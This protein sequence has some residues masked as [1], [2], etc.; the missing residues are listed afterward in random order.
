MLSGPS[1]VGQTVIKSYFGSQ[2]DKPRPTFKYQGFGAQSLAPD[3]VRRF[4]PRPIDPQLRMEIESET[5]INS[6]GGAQFSPDGKTLYFH[7]NVSGA[8]QIWKLSPTVPFPVQMTSGEDST[9]L[10]DITPDGLSLIESRDHGG[11]EY[12][13]IYRQKSSGGRLEP[14][15]VK[16]QVKAEPQFI[17]EDGRYLY[18]ISNEKAPTSYGIYKLDLKT[19]ERQVVLEDPGLWSVADHRPDGTLLLFK[20]TAHDATEFFILPPNSLK[21]EPLFGQGEHDEYQ[22]RFGSHEGEVLVLTNKFG[23]FRRLY[24]YR[25]KQ[26]IPLTPDIHYDVSGFQV[27]RQRKRILYTINQAGEDS[28]GALDAKTLRPLKLPRLPQ[29][30]HVGWGNTTRDGRRT[31]VTSET[32]TKPSEAFIYDW[33][34]GTIE[35]RLEPSMPEL[36]TTDFV[37]PQLTTYPAQDG[38]DIPVILWRRSECEKRTCPAIVMFHGGPNMEAT[39]HFNPEIQFLLKKG[40]TVLEP[41]VRGSEGFGKSWQKADDGAKRLNVI[42]DIADAADY[43]RKKLKVG[44]VPPRVGAFG[45]SYG[46]YSVLMGM[47]MFA[48]KY[49]AGFEVIGIANLRSYLKNTAAYRAQL[50]IS[51]YG[52]PDKDIDVIEKLSPITYLN[53]IKNPIMIVHG[54]NDPK[55]PVGE[56]YEL[57][58]RLEERGQQPELIIFPNEGHGV[59]KLSNRV[60]L[61]GY[62]YEFFK[63]HLQMKSPSVRADNKGWSMLELFGPANH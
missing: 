8:F 14:L 28:L 29:A 16:S 19:L 25:N 58:T 52:D 18:F 53:R 10:F 44:D 42:T 31:M 63:T 36:D 3:I 33:K 51:E 37:Q 38:V 56:A 40:F 1:A 6:P 60:L 24:S 7:W 23:E 50:R 30:L 62:V 21:P 45:F 39:P 34:T 55:V 2:Q 22:G 26:F 11:D 48:G 61:Q 54:L 46:G 20:H 5:G 13:G 35:K 32:A 27:D 43:A 59:D 57:Y 12:A 15:F 49:D 4:L 47:S 41:N 9:F 17:S